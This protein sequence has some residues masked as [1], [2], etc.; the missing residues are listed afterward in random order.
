MDWYKLYNEVEMIRLASLEKEAGKP[1]DF[2]SAL[3]L[4]VSLFLEGASITE[5]AEIAKV[6]TEAVQMAAKNP[7]IVSRAK[8]KTSKSKKLSKKD[9]I[10]DIIART[11]YAEA[12]GESFEGKKA[13]AS[14]IY[15]RAKGNLDRFVPKIKEKYQF[16]CWN[17]GT[18]PLGKGSVWEDCLRIAQ[19]MVDGKFTPTVTSLYYYNP[20]AVSETPNWAEGKKTKR[21]GNH[22]FLL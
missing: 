18:P 21:I 20:D 19:E 11:I 9:I 5:A 10:K 14:V 22:L 7:A 13:V 15:N 8:A 16:S 3:I 1:E 2:L 4:A 12:Q 17:K 6:K